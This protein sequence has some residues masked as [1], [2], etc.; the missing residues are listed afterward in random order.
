MRIASRCGED[1]RYVSEGEAGRDEHQE[2]HGAVDNNGRNHRARERFGC[3][4]EFFAEM[5]GT[6][7]NGIV[8]RMA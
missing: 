2:T 3:I 5:S 6:K 8:S 4:S 7:R 1:T